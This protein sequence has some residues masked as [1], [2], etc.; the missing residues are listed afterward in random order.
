MNELEELLKTEKSGRM[1]RLK[2]EYKL[3]LSQG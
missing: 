3:N 2:G 1:I